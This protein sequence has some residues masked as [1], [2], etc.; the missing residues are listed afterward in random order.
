MIYIL[1][2]DTCFGIAC[3]LD[4][5]KSYERIYKIKK[6]SLDKPLA[7]LVPDFNWLEKNTELTKEQVNFLKTYNK[8]FTILTESPH[9]SVWINFVNDENGEEFLNRGV[10][11]KF[12]FRV[13]NN[14]TQDRLLKENGP[15]FM[16]SAN[17]S[18][19]PEIYTSREIKEK[20]A[21]ALEK[22]H[23]KFVGENT[24]V[25]PKN[26]P[27]EIFEFVGETLEQKFIRK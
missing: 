5:I 15:M 26:P 20:F 6:R 11:E 27:S 7:I 24:G 18:N 8:P 13:A 16:T 12:A 21:E 22:G 23:I 1:P 3:G 17:I 19:E 25:I 9:V 14:K 4:D 10:Y 2:T